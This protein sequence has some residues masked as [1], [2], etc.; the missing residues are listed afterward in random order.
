MFLTED[1]VQESKGKRGLYRVQER[2]TERA[3]V[4][5]QY[6]LARLYPRVATYRGYIK[7]KVS[8]ECVHGL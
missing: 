7:A 1:L 4:L 5:P 3:F 8:T 6:T 2:H